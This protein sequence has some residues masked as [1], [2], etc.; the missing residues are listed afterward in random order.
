MCR[1]QSVTNGTGVRMP[2]API[3]PQLRP[4]CGLAGP[5]CAVSCAENCV[6]RDRTGGG[7]GGLCNPLILRY[8]QLDSSRRPVI[9]DSSFPICLAGQIHTLACSH[10][11]TVCTV[12]LRLPVQPL[13]SSGRSRFDVPHSG[14]I[15]VIA[16]FLV[17]N[18]KATNVSLPL[19]SL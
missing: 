7:G 4:I 1:F 5:F 2:S 18:G 15:L 8:V 10:I 9:R 11:C 6:E 19:P 12:S 16:S 17:G 3:R 13:C 14:L